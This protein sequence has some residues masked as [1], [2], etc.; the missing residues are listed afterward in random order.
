MNVSEEEEEI[1]IEYFES[2]ETDP[3]CENI[4]KCDTNV[5]KQS[6]IPN[7]NINQQEMINTISDCREKHEY[8]VNNNQNIFP[9]DS[10][11]EDTW[12]KCIDSQGRYLCKFCDNSYSTIQTVRHHVKTKHC[13]KWNEM[14]S[15]GILK[16]RRRKL[17]CH[18]CK[19]L[20]KNM[21]NLQEHTKSHGVE[22]IQK[23]C[24]ICHATFNNDTEILTHL[25]NEHESVKRKLHHC[26]LCGYSTPKL[27]H[28]KQHEKTHLDVKQIKCSKCD[29]TTYHT[30]NMKIHERIHLND[31]PYT[32]L[33]PD[34]GY[35]CATKSGLSSHELQ[36]GKERKF[37]Y[38]DKCNYKTVYK[39]SLKKHIDS[40]RR[41][42][43][44]SKF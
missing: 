22:N 17:K 2:F 26:S 15:T 38:C 36:H 37:I 25:V 28:F 18:I 39:Q 31:K 35:Q 16:L 30:S 34:C 1:K 4:A 14:K 33:F 23:S 32:C 20:F 3:L 6:N 41:N 29:Y 42:S 24:F 12:Y 11:A 9:V 43:L 7:E 27:S 8:H 40:H 21:L 19:K 44:K 5:T 13:D 10:K